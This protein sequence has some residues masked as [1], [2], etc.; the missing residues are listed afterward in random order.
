[1]DHN[2]SGFGRHC[3]LGGT[4]TSAAASLPAAAGSLDVG[5]LRG[6]SPASRG[7]ADT[8]AARLAAVCTTAAALTARA[9]SL[10]ISTAS[11]TR[12]AAAVGVVV[13][14]TVGVGLGATGLDDD[15]LSVHVVRIGRKCCLVSCR[16]RELDEGAVLIFVSHTRRG[17]E[18]D[19]YI[20]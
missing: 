16:G 1:M 11:S 20:P 17:R 12:D 6:S 10:K 18:Q 2:S 13:A 9:T 14:T 15:A 5:D 8:T 3:H 4:T 19:E 7:T